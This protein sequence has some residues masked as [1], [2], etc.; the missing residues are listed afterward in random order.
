MT[1]L[2]AHPLRTASYLIALPG[3]KQS[4]IIQLP[5]MKH[6]ENQPQRP[7]HVSVSGS[8][9]S[10]RR[11]RL[12]SR[13]FCR[14]LAVAGLGFVI[15][16]FVSGS[17]TSVVNRIKCRF[18]DYGWA[19]DFDRDGCDGLTVN[20]GLVYP[21]TQGPDGD[22]GSAFKNSSKKVPL[23]AH[24]MSKCPDARDCLQQLVV[25]AM[26][27]ISDRVNFDLSFIAR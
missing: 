26:E 24:I 5:I 1:P 27:Q 23:E 4:I 11:D 7:S 3:A 10:N 14:I 25:P 2:E 22:Y 13:F 12:I 8:P 20:D 19:R 18:Q 9:A 17:F 15:Y 21:L 16:L 6:L